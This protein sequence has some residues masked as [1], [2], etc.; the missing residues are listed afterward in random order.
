[1]TKLFPVVANLLSSEERIMEEKNPSSQ[2]QIGTC[3][4]LLPELL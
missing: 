2:V 3:L 1:M 4:T